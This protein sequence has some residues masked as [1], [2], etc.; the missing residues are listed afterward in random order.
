MINSENKMNTTQFAKSQAVSNVRALQTFERKVLLS[1]WRAEKFSNVT[2]FR[3]IV[4]Q[5]LQRKNLGFSETELNRQTQTYSKNS[6]F[7]EDELMEL[8]KLNF[9]DIV[10][11]SA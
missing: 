10:T 4:L 2:F 7:I 1:I 9:V 5:N 6:I 11:T 8:R 3:Q